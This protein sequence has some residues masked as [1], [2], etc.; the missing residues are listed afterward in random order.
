MSEKESLFEKIDITKYSVKKL[1]AIPLI[2]LLVSLALLTSTQLSINSP[3]HLGMDFRGGTWVKISTDETREEL[4]AKFSDYPVTL[5]ANT[6]VGNERR[7]E[8]DLTS[9]SQ[10]YDL[11]IDMLNKEYG[12]G[13]YE[14]ESISPVFGKQYQ[15]QALRALTIAFVLMAIVVFIVFRTFIPSLAVIFAAFS[16][17]IIAVACM[18]VIGMELSLGT[19]AALLML[20]GYSVDS[21]ILLTTNLLRKKGELNEKVRNA[22]RTGITMTSTT[23][24]AV[25]AMF[26][27][28]FY[29]DIYILRAISVVL[30][31]GLTMDLLNTWLLNAGI[32]RWYV[33]RKERKKYKRRG[34]EEVKV[35]MKKKGKSIK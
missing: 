31:F 18:N 5:I 16:D 1:V 20:I 17:I 11:L 24:S 34:V 28:S 30:L 9:S 27:V 35:K 26:L 29:L 25:F 15:T 8:F 14:I 22:M 6:G 32:L 3:V 7:I 19:V 2:I 10:K 4:I 33:E 21:D 13:T 23:L 12:V